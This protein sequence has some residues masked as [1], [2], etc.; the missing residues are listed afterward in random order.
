[1][2]TLCWSLFDAKTG[3]T[4]RGMDSIR[5]L[6]G[7][8]VSGSRSWKS[9][10]CQICTSLQKKF[11]LFPLVPFVVVGEETHCWCH[12]CTAVILTLLSHA[13]A[14]ARYRE[15]EF[16]SEDKWSVGCSAHPLSTQSSGPVN[17]Y[18]YYT[19]DVFALRSDGRAGRFRP[20]QGVSVDRLRLCC[21][22]TQRQVQRSEPSAEA[23]N[24]SAFARWQKTN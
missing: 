15:D 11:H 1:M 19:P 8:V 21:A 23:C 13:G 14:T 16:V 3:L 6:T 9:S 7:S 5:P 4:C 24:T 10:Y 2:A 12:L 20:N 17:I 18:P 22:A